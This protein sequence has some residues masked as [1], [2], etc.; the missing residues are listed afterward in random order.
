[1]VV[2]EAPGV[3]SALGLLWADLRAD[4]SGTVRRNVAKE[5]AA[6]IQ[7]ALARLEAEAVAWLDREK[8]PAPRRTLL[9]SAEM[10]YPLQNYE[11]NVPLPAGKVDAAWLA[12]ARDAFHAAHERLYSYCDREEA[13]QLVNLR[14]AAVGRTDRPKPRPL[15]RGPASAQAALK[16][17]RKVHFQASGRFVDA[18]IYERD[19]LR[20]GNRIAGPAVI[21]QADSTIIVP[22]SFVAVVDVH[23]RIVISSVL[24]KKVS[25]KKA[26]WSSA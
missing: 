17:R 7:A 9:R 8:V 16:E 18:P 25:R 20:A 26:E 12:R 2:P 1:V 22:P 10:R 11:I 21:E 13:V 23:G 3:F 5:N 4:F 15:Q 19:R 14:V 24:N 6:E